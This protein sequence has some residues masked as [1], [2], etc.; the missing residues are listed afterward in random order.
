[1]S[2]ATS[3]N[4]TKPQPCYPKRQSQQQMRRFASA[5]LFLRSW[6]QHS[7][8]RKKNTFGRLM[9]PFR[10]TKID[11]L[12]NHIDKLK[13]TLQLLMQVLTHAHQIASRKLDREAEA[14]Q[15]E[16]IKALIQNK[17]ESTKRYEESLRD[18]NLSEGSTAISDDEGNGKENQNPT[19]EMEITI[20]ASAISSTITTKSLETCVQHIQSLLEDIENLQ[21]VLSS[22]DEGKNPSE[23]QQSLIGSYFR[24]HGHL[25]TVILGSSKGKHGSDLDHFKS[26]GRAVLVESKTKNEEELSIQKT[27]T[28]STLHTTESRTSQEI[29]VQAVVQE[30]QSG[31]G[32]PEK[33]R[34]EAEF[35]KA[36]LE[37]QGN[38]RREERE[39]IAEEERVREEHEKAQTIAARIEAERLRAEV[40]RNAKAEHE[41]IEAKTKVEAI[42]QA[43]K[44]A[45]EELKVAL[46]KQQL[47]IKLK[48]AAGRTYKIPFHSCKPWKEMESLLNRAFTHGRP[49]KARVQD[50]EYDLIGPDR[51]IILP[52]FWESMIQP[53]WTITMRMWPVNEPSRSR[54]SSFNATQSLMLHKTPGRPLPTRPS[55]SDTDGYFKQPSNVDVFAGD[56]LFQEINQPIHLGGH[57]PRAANN[58]RHSTRV[59]E[60]MS[61]T[62]YG[63]DNSDIEAAAGLAAFALSRRRGSGRGST[64]ESARV[65]SDEE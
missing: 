51:D 14:A 50:G 41:A 22:Q 61:I 34:L 56:S 25:D 33:A 30:E 32:Q 62:G 28:G 12:R 64:K 17:K 24:A 1:M 19:T 65:S 5:P 2:W 11:L 54:E 8:R 52:Q 31:M 21:Q 15:R 10:E 39:K 29:V 13:S 38:A 37:A 63:S 3:S 57:S 53:G 45:E 4:R 9:L 35:K 55:E 42:E 58:Q 44:A 6:M 26:K 7:G 40:E 20:F 16:Q 49:F 18:F 23:H 60:V 46:L 36:I 43:K 59:N 27:L 47:P 48:D